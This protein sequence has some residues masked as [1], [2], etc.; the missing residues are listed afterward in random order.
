VSG[1]F[2][3]DAV[4]Q[5]VEP[6]DAGAGALIGGRGIC[7]GVT[8][9]IRAHRVVGQRIAQKEQAAAALFGVAEHTEV[10]LEIGD[11]AAGDPL[12]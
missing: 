3:A 1:E 2:A 7:V 10:D 6:V 8:D 9:S 4:F 11:A 5:L 12:I